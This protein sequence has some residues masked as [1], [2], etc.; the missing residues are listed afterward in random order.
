MSAC[1]IDCSDS[2]TNGSKLANHSWAVPVRKN[3]NDDM[4]SPSLTLVS[5]Y[6][7]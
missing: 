2:F 3:N 4:A 6:K 7:P 5:L 1:L